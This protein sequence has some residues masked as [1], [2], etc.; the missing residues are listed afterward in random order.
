MDKKDIFIAILAGGKGER[1]WPKSRAGFPKQNL[2]LIGEKTIFQD[3]FG[4][5]SKISPLNIFIITSKDNAPNI[6]GQLR[7][8]KSKTI[9]AEPFGRNTAPAIGLASLLAHRKNRNAVVLAMPSDHIIRDDSKFFVTIRHAI[10]EAK[11]TESIILVGIKPH[12]AESAYGYIGIDENISKVSPRHSS[13]ITEFIEK[14]DLARAR[15]LVSSGRYFWNSGIFIFKASTM[16]SVLEKHMPVL[17]GGLK[18]LPDLK[19]KS[20]FNRELRKLYAKLESKSLDYAVLEKSKKIRVIP[21]R[22]GWSDIGSFNSIVRMAKKD[23]DGN[24]VFG[25]HVGLD[26]KESVIFSEKGILV[27]T[28]GIKDIIV[29]ATPDAILVCDKKRPEDI[30]KLVEKIKKNKRLKMF[31]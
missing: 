16:L 19:K 3:T 27:G 5:A 8:F 29:V 28:I 31:L 12:S 17:H 4:R 13:R 14:P 25:E 10:N 21:S 2:K 7:L 6:A 11:K 18:P 23:K 22:F 24:A 15:K 1:L 9:V 20:E 30:K 26:T